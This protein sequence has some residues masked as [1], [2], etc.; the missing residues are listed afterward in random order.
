MVLHPVVGPLAAMV[1]FAEKCRLRPGWMTRVQWRSGA[2]AT[3]TSAGCAV[4]TT[5]V[6]A[7]S[8]VVVGLGYQVDTV[9]ITRCSTRKAVMADQI[10]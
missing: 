3:S 4:C 7:I 2:K 1:V 8:V 5:L 10:L 9:K 6:K